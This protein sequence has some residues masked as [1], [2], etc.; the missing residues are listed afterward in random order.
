MLRHVMVNGVLPLSEIDF[1]LK[2]SS[3]RRTLALQ[4]G[5]KG[6]V[7]H[8]PLYLPEQVINEFVA[9]KSDWVQQQ[10]EKL[11][12]PAQQQLRLIDGAWLP[13]LDERILLRIVTDKH[14]A[15]TLEGGCLWV[16]LSQRI[17]PEN[18]HKTQ[19]A[20]VTEWYQQEAYRC[21]LARLEVFAALMRLTFTDLAIKNWQ[22]KWGTCDSRGR[23]CLNWRL[24]LVP[25]W[26]A[27]YVVIH[28]LAHRQHMNHSADF[29]Q[30]VA[31]YCPKWQ[32]ARQYLKEHQ[33]SLEFE[34]PVA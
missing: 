5:P 11:Q 2:R 29:W 23:I 14:S 32:Q 17:K 12:V 33:H 16:Q 27:D 28:E 22:T 13:L 9:R 19:R 34:E 25:E 24:L 30:L 10:L 20:L 26:V 6:V 21:L 7:V 3:R 15:V 4:V 18:Q 31:H 1:Q 8:A